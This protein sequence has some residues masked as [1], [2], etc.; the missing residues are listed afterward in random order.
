MLF[1]ENKDPGAQGD[2]TGEVN[3]K[4]QNNF[5]RMPGGMA[6]MFPRVTCKDQLPARTVTVNDWRKP[7]MGG[8]A[9]FTHQPHKRDISTNKTSILRHQAFFTPGETDC[10]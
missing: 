9:S 1:E 3:E 7:G 8:R 4:I 6:Y 5:N 10:K 2:S